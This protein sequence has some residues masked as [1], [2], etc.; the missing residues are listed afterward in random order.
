[1]NE[2]KLT[3]RAQRALEVLKSGGWF[4]YRLERDSYTG[5]E[6]FQTRLVAAGNHVVKGYGFAVKD[7]L[8][9]AGLIKENFAKG[10]SVSSY[11]ELAVT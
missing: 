4:R 6:Q 8:E 1:M 11:Y 3:P 10:T 9:R 7:E 2:I 5:R